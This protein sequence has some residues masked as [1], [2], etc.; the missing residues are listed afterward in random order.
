MIT[1]FQQMHLWSKALEQEAVGINFDIWL[2][3]SN[4]YEYNVVYEEYTTL[5]GKTGR[6]HGNILLHSCWDHIKSKQGR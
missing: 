5:E 4:V 3:M 6:S 2:N 1:L